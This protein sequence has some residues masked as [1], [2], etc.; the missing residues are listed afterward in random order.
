MPR[1]VVTDPYGGLE[2]R[3]ARQ[4][5]LELVPDTPIRQ[6]ILLGPA[7]PPGMWFEGLRLNDDGAHPNARGARRMADWVAASLGRMGL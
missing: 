7:L 4:H 5:G 2:R 1:G 6:I 3:L